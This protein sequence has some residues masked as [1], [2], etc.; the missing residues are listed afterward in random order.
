M[1]N[2][3]WTVL[4]AAALAG[5]TAFQ[6]L[7]G[8]SNQ[9]QNPNGPN[10]ARRTDIKTSTGTVRSYSPQGRIVIVSADGAEHA[11]PLDGGARVADG[12]VEGQMVAVAWLT[13]S[14]GHPRVTSIAPVEP[15]GT[16]GSS[17]SSSSSSAPPSKAYASAND[18][19]TMSST[20]SGP[21]SETPRPVPTEA[22]VYVTP[23]AR[24]L[25]PAAPTPAPGRGQGPEPTPSRSAAPGAAMP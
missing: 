3:W 18:G 2:I 21:M 9:D 24:S 23:G 6:N 7:P 5:A 25:T 1:K 12:V 13:E 20:P 15:P 14:T 11:F 4:A 16:A 8:D 19:A 10:G 22:S 17:A